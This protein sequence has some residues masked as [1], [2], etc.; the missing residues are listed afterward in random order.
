MYPEP[1]LSLNY[2]LS[3]ISSLKFGATKN[4]Q[5]LH[6]V[7]VSSITLPT[8]VWMPSSQLI[9][10]QSGEQYSLG[11]YRTFKHQIEAST[12][13]YYKRMDHLNYNQILTKTFSLV[14]ERVMVLNG[15]FEK[16]VANLQ[17]GLDIP[18]LPLLVPFRIL[19]TEELFGR[20]TTGETT[21]VAC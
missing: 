5:Y 13:V 6:L 12:E 15:C 14:R 8:D 7:P 21:L 1:R 2:Q 19:K 17:D 11:Y 9:Q 10:P 20:K 16:V 18:C 3:A 4:Y